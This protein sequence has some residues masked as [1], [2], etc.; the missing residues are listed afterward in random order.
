MS[1]RRTEQKGNFGRWAVVYITN[2]VNRM[3][4]NEGPSGTPKGTHYFVDIYSHDFC[5]FGLYL[6]YI[7]SNPICIDFFFI[8]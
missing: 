2:I 8:R 7:T 3:G 5:V 4:P 1:H 6:L